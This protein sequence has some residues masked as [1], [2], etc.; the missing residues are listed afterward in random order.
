MDVSELMVDY[1]KRI[2]LNLIYIVRKLSK[3]DKGMSWFWQ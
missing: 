3:L 2:K 1:L